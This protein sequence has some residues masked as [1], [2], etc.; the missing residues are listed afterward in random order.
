MGTTQQNCKN[1]KE[2][3]RYPCFRA[4][5]RAYEMRGGAGISGNCLE[6]WNMAIDFG[7]SYKRQLVNVVLTYRQCWHT[8]GACWEAGRRMSVIRSLTP[9]YVMWISQE[10]AI[11][12]WL[13]ASSKSLSS[14][15]WLS[16]AR[17]CVHNCSKCWG[18]CA[19]WRRTS[20]C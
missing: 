18:G 3:P 11:L 14:V 6:N 17:K 9:S 13:R 16:I 15:L 4:G 20:Y 1:K 5:A 19:Q 2:T 7:I 10:R 12:Y 8:D